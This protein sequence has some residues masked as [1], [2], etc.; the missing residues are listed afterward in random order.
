MTLVGSWQVEVHLL[1]ALDGVASAEAAAGDDSAAA[2]GA[3]A[4][5]ELLAGHEGSDL[6][7]VGGVDLA[8]LDGVVGGGGGHGGGSEEGGNAEDDS[9]ELHV[10]GLR[11]G[12]GLC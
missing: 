2:V 10:E 11:A 12:N 6:V 4:L 9:G 7:N 3:V 8:D 5:G 1:G